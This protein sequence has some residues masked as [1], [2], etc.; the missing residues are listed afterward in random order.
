MTGAGASPAPS[1]TAGPPIR[2]A[3][4][5]V[6]LRRTEAGPRLL[7]GQR[8]SGAVFM[9]DKY[10][11]P[12]GA[13]DPEDILRAAEEGV[14]E[15]D[16]RLT[17]ETEPGL[18]RALRHAAIR[19]LREETGL[20]LPAPDALRFFFRAVTPPGRPRRF[21][22]RFFLADAAAIAGSPD[23]FTGAEDELR[24]LNWVSLEEARA[25]DLPFITEIVLAEIAAREAEAGGARPVPY[26][27]HT[28]LGSH[29]HL[30]RA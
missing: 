15:T 20:S 16:P 27:N 10:V 23:D 21:D 12:G 24:F 30:L 22:A 6:I 8:G 18:A 1:L 29:F 11:F 4:T 14:A 7:M 25:L 13:V 26:F 2:H 19:E 3:A 28:D 5:I 17:I 9:P